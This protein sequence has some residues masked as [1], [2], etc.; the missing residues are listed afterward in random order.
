MRL[1]L[2][3]LLVWALTKGQETWR[4]RSPEEGDAGHLT[5]TKRSTFGVAE[6]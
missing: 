5:G 2:A 3:E 4:V 6:W 1:V